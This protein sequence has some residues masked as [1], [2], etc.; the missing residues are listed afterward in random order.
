MALINV[1]KFSATPSIQEL[2]ESRLIKAQWTA[3]AVA[4]E[5]KVSSG[6]MKAQITCITI[7]ALM[8]SGKIDKE[9]GEAQELLNV[10]KAEFINK[11]EQ[12]KEKSDAE[13][14]L[15][16]R[17]EEESLIKLKMQAEKERGEREES[18]LDPVFDV[19]RVQKLILKFTEEAPD[20]FF[21][22]FERVASVSQ[23]TYRRLMLSASCEEEIVIKHNNSQSQLVKWL[24]VT[25]SN[26][27]QRAV[28]G[29]LELSMKRTMSGS[30]ET[31]D[32]SAPEGSSEG[33][34]S[35]EEL[36]QESEVSPSVSNEK[37]SQEEEDSVVL[38]ETQSSQS[39]PEDSSETTV[40]ENVLRKE[41][42]YL[43]QH[44]LAEPSSS[45]YSST[46]L[47]VKK[48]DGSF[49]EEQLKSLRKV[50]KK[51]WEAGLTINLQKI[52]GEDGQL[53]GGRHP[54]TDHDNDSKQQPETGATEA[55]Q[56]KKWTREENKEYGDATSEAT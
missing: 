30:E 9:L 20:E 42:E 36:F 10:A 50:F 24:K 3:L 39:V 6:M 34:L 56:K 2:S 46:C 44:G 55:N 51:L 26:R 11:Q 47:L 48:P 7:Q 28:W 16:C 5:A 25:K 32:L 41:A 8:D 53:L 18:N 27:L 14:E 23:D 43:L 33:S 54:A 31:E 1:Q 29:R 13:V 52:D 15:R 17:A 12:K 38:E 49:R 37:I 40:A 4:C 21:D 45:H 19:V 22:H 35:L